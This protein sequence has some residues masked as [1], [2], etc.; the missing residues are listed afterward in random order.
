MALFGIPR[1]LHL[2][3]L[4]TATAIGAMSLLGVGLGWTMRLGALLHFI[5]AAGVTSEAGGVG[6]PVQE[7]A[8][9]STVRRLSA[10]SVEASASDLASASA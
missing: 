1:K 5:M 10:S 9:Q 3:G 7:W 2:D 4:L 8:S 6:T